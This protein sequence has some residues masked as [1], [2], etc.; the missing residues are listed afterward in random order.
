MPMKGLIL[1]GGYGT[2]LRPLTLTCPKPL[3][4]FCNKPLI[5]HQIE[6][7]AKAGV[8]DIILAVHYGSEVMLPMFKECEEKYGVNIIISKEEEP[9][10]TAGPLKLVEDI[11]RKD[12][13][14]FFVLNGDVICDY[15]LRELAEFHIASGGRATMAAAKVD[16]PSKYGVIVSNPTRENLIERFVEKPQEYIG[17][18]VNAG[19]YILNPDVLDMIELRP[20]SIVR[21]VFPKL[22]EEHS[23]YFFDLKGFW[24]DIGEPREYLIG[25]KLYLKDIA[26]KGSNNLATGDNIIGNVM[27]DPSAKISPTAVIGPDVVIG[28]NVVVEDGVRIKESVILAATTI[29]A[30][31]FISLTTVGWESHI[32]RWCWLEGITVLGKDTTVK[33]EV[34]INACKVLPHKT[35]TTS[36]TES[37]IIM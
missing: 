33:D 35:I 6:A 9:L 18:R 30:Y 19:L 24:I 8:K 21:E 2:R 28:P 36:F 15:P 31:S 25:T 37:S 16:E 22:A 17:N 27:I 7:L 34:Y 20:M 4:E 32:G 23:L 11:L 5:L 12:E 3:V 26:K 29:E 10:D 14:P 1:V 13:S